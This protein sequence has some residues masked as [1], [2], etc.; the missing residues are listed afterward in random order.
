MNPGEARAGA[1]VSGLM[2][3]RKGGFLDSEELSAFP[4]RPAVLRSRPV[5]KSE[6]SR[7]QLIQLGIGGAAVL[8]LGGGLFRWLGSGYALGP[9]EVAIGLSVKQLCVARAL[10]EALVPGGDGMPS[11]R[12]LRLQQRV[13][14]QIWAADDGMAGDLRAALELIEHAPPLFGHFGRFTSLGL[15]ARQEVFDQMLRSRRDLFVQVALAFKQLIQLCYFADERVWPAIGYDGPW[16][17]EAKPPASALAY[18]KLFADRG[19]RA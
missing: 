19:G 16:I 7:R 18:A 10:V 5:A 13:D 2:Q 4:A 17:T 11:G 15:E 8:A 1:I 3:H 6:P 9:G 14:E 12:E